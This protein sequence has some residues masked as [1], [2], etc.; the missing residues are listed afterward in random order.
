M[1]YTKTEWKEQTGNGLNKFIITPSGD[2]SIIVS[3]PDSIT[4]TGTAFNIG[5]MNKIEQGIYD[6]HQMIEANFNTLTSHADMVEEAGR[7]LLTV[8]GAS[9][10][11]DV[12]AKLRVRCN[13]TGTPNFSGLMLGDYLDIPSMTID[14]TGYTFNSSYKNLRIVV[15]GFNTFKGVG[16]TENANNHILFTF[17]N[18]V[19]QKRINPTDVNTGG[20]VSSELRAWLEGTNGD[21]TGDYSGV[22]TAAF[23][24]GLKN[25][26]G[27]YLHTI[28]KA[29]SIKGT[30][31]WKSYT[32][33][34][35]SEIEVFGTPVWGDEG[36]YMPALTSPVLP[37]RATYITPIQF[38]IYQKSFAY[39]IKCYNGFRAW[40]WEQT[41]TAAYSTD[42]CGV[43]SNGLANYTI[44]SSASGG[45]APAFCVA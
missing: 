25:A 13:G 31:N 1:A 19:L 35:P 2:K 4:Q 11:A 33:F 8:L 32:V 23:M 44:A 27:N 30:Y 17:R 24:T 7:N 36:V 37:A 38:P 45:V 42:F 12:M 39:R 43:G 15:S 21:G 40:Y 14:G 18:C 9:S 34:L 28:H 16:D 3:S 29:H 10:V 6:A 26:I 5:D 41:P 22:T 20:Y